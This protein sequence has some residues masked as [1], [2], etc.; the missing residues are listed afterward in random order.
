[1]WSEVLLIDKKTSCSQIEAI[2]LA[3]NTKQ[4]LLTQDNRD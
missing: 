4:S 2:L 1:M 3:T